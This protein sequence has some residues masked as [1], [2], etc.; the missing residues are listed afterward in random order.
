MCRAKKSRKTSK[1][2][3][4]QLL[5]RFRFS[6]VCVECV[7]RHKRQSRTSEKDRT[8]TPQNRAWGWIF[9]DTIS[10]FFWNKNVTHITSFCDE[11]HIDLWHLSHKMWRISHRFFIFCR[12][13]LW[14]R[15]T[16]RL[17]NYIFLVIYLCDICH[18]YILILENEDRMLRDAGTDF[19]LSLKEEW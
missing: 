16:K 10:L 8:P 7:E 5:F 17:A 3:S 12:I 19:K 2:P 14:H 1:N 11:Y 6:F 15:I 4:F 9:I 18:I 13:L